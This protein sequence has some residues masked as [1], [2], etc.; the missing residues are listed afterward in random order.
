MANIN[1]IPIRFYNTSDPYTSTVDNRPIEDLNARI[2]MVNTHLESLFLEIVSARG[3][4]Q[5]LNQ[6]L[7]A[8][9]LANGGIDP[10]ATFN[11]LAA[12]VVEENTPSENDRVWMTRK[13][14]YKLSLIENGSN[15]FR[16]LLPNENSPLE[17]DVRLIVGNTIRIS[18]KPS[19]DGK[20]LLYIDTVLS[21]DRL[22]EHRYDQ[23]ILSFNDGIAN[24]DLSGEKIISGSLKVFLNGIRLRKDQFLEIVDSDGSI[25]GFEI[26]DTDLII[27][28]AFDSLTVDYDI[29]P[30]IY[31][32]STSFIQHGNGS[33][34]RYQKM[35]NSLDL[36]D[37]SLPI[38][39]SGAQPFLYW[40]FDITN[41]NILP[42]YERFMLFITNDTR[43]LSDGRVQAS[44]GIDWDIVELSGKKYIRW[45]YDSNPGATSGIPDEFVTPERWHFLVNHGYGNM[46]SPATQFATFDIDVDYHFEFFYYS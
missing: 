10:N 9:L 25:V 11:V 12:N 30:S 6:R 28:L 2:V 39:S 13:E 41:L 19:K 26:S 4:E 46:E 1:S 29:T 38:G 7:S 5:S 20:D 24:I 42:P 22:H 21:A 3:S 31:D 27:D 35:V 14:K 32:K 15:V 33:I 34:K 36:V 40:M 8:S 23:R 17:G 18:R 43:I 44:Y 37:I 45:R 16:I